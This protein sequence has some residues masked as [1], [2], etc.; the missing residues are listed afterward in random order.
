LFRS[1]IKYLISGP[2]VALELLGENAIARWQE[3]A[4]PEDSECARSTMASSLR[5]RYGKDEIH[6]AVH[7]SENCETAVQVC[8]FLPTIIN[9]RICLDFSLMLYALILSGVTIFLS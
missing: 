5:A 4:G 8:K 1:A 3:L 6:N 2:V 9:S 7:G